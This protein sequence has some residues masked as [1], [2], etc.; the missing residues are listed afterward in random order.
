MIFTMC[1]IGR[2]RSMRML[3]LLTITRGW[4]NGL[5]RAFRVENSNL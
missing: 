3:F 2:W 4:V 5:E 1:V